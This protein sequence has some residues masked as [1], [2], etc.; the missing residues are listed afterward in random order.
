MWGGGDEKVSSKNRIAVMYCTDVNKLKP[1]VHLNGRLQGYELYFN[2][3]V[4]K[5]Q[6]DEV[7]KKIIT[8]IFPFNTHI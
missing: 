3:I 8:K 5:K 7:G 1:I 6:V 2:K 4:L